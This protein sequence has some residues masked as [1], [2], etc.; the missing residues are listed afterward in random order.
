LQGVY[1]AFHLPVQFVVM[2]GSAHGG[3]AFTSKATLTLIDGFLQ[4]HL[5]A[6]TT[7]P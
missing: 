4:T 5:L 7:T 3:P 1:E 6:K 2:H